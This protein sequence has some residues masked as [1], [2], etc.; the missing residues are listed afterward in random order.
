MKRINVFFP[1]ALPIFI[2]VLNIADFLTS[3]LQLTIN[4][5]KSLTSPFKGQSQR[6]RQNHYFSSSSV[7][8]NLKQKGH[9][10]IIPAMQLLLRSDVI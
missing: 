9:N 7:Q 4:K 6:G 3:L 10:N 2:S 1:I 8:I 5:I